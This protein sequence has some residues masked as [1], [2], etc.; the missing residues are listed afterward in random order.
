MSYDLGPCWYRPVVKIHAAR[1]AILAINP[2]TTRLIAPI[3]MAS[4][5]QSRTH[6]QHDL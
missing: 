6:P 2:K 1:I 4:E 5:V 3:L